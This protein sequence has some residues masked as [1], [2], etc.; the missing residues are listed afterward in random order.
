MF[1]NIIN[2]SNLPDTNFR[3]EKAK[4]WFREQAQQVRNVDTKALL[5][6]SR[7]HIRGRVL[8]GQLYLFAYDPK[9][10]DT[11][12][13]WDR[14]PLVFPFRKESNGFYGLNMHYLPIQLR[15]RLMDALYDQANND[16]FD[17]TTRLRLSYNILNSAAKFRYFKPCVKFYLNNQIDSR[18]YFIHPDEWEIAL[19]L[20]IHKFKN[21]RPSEVHKDSRNIIAGR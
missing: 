10:K 1:Q 12:P 9:H 11:L 20:P 7:E 19:F 6:K 15:A 18:I 4:Q 13:Y 5:T 14:Y 8:T 3:S 16:E 17:E 21:A 2:I